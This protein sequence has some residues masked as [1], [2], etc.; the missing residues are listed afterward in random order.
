MEKRVSKRRGLPSVDYVD[1]EFV[2]VEPRNDPIMAIE[3]V[4]IEPLAP[5]VPIAV[6]ATEPAAGP[7]GVRTLQ[8]RVTK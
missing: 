4:A 1:G 6:P 8:V 3:P 2:R 5:I 7:C